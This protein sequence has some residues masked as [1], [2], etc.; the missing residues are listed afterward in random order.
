MFHKKLCRYAVLMAI[1]SIE[2][3]IPQEMRRT[4]SAAVNFKSLPLVMLTVHGAQWLMKLLKKNFTR[5]CRCFELCRIR[6]SFAVFPFWLSTRAMATLCCLVVLDDET[7]SIK[8]VSNS[9]SPAIVRCVFHLSIDSS[10]FFSARVAANFIS[11]VFIH[12]SF[13]M[14]RVACRWVRV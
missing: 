4:P 12:Y 13:E 2:K 8:S 9:W 6:F 3:S 7:K 1:R 14:N 5:Q 10:F 11:F